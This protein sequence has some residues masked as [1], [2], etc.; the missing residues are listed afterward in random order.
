MALWKRIA[1]WL[2][3]LL[4]PVLTV[5]A[6]LVFSIDRSIKIHPGIARDIFEQCRTL[7]E[8]EAFV[9]GPPGDYTTVP[10]SFGAPD[11]TAEKTK[12]IDRFIESFRRNGRRWISDD[13]CVM[14]SLD[15]SGRIDRTGEVRVYLSRQPNLLD[16]VKK[17]F[18]LSYV[19]E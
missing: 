9:G 1:F 18:R 14:V 3:V 15:A 17:R 8:V 2:F 10:Y 13:G 16:K 7:P 4:V 6:I 19:P 12:D 5:V 11:A